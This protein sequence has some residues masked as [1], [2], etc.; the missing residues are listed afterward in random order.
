MLNK[1]EIHPDAINLGLRKIYRQGR[2]AFTAAAG[3]TTTASI[4][5]WRKKNKYFA[6]AVDVLGKG[7]QF[8]QVSLAKKAARLGDWL[9]EE[10]DLAVLIGTIHRDTRTLSATSNERLQGAIA[11]R[12]RKLQKK[13][14]RLGATL[15]AKKAKKVVKQ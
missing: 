15:Y 9:G 10:H 7:A 12:R 3:R 6:N 11:S 8:R 14:L 13:A 2:K 4:H 5:E 1:K